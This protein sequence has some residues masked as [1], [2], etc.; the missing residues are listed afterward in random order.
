MKRFMIMA[1]ALGL[2]FA[3]G[4]IAHQGFASVVDAFAAVSWGVI[5]VIALRALQMAQAGAGWWCIFP[6]PRLSLID[7]INIRLVREAINTLLPVAQIGGEIAGARLATFHRVPGGLA[8]ATVLVDLLIQIVTQFLFTLV[9][10]ALLVLSG[11]GA[12][13][14]AAATTGLVAMA[15]A[16]LG[17]FGVQRF[18][19]F[20]WIDRGLM[21]LAGASG[22][23]GLAGIANIHDQLEIV[24]SNW[25]RLAGASVLH[26]SVWLVGALEI[27]IAL[28][29]MGYA[30]S[31]AEALI[32]ESLSQAVRAAAFL[33]PGAFGVQEGGFIAICAVFVIPAPAA[34]ALSLVKR[35]P[36]LALGLPYLLVWQACEGRALLR[37]KRVA[38]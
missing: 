10:V 21:K 23:S 6:D 24:H 14:T 18:G 27:Y 37:H 22:W 3:I 28:H 38:P 35:V 2:M 1:A 17:F 25:T 7:C 4:I 29:F 16:F 32:I 15:I 30:V 5:I 13:L 33:V 34:L 9:G 11:A 19:G 12:T 26:L 36:D 8:V 31:F 20:R